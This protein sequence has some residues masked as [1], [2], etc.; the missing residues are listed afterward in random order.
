MADGA[1]LGA[2]A[3][4]PD[5]NIYLKSVYTC[6]NKHIFKDEFRDDLPKT[7]STT[8]TTTTTTPTTTTTFTTTTPTTTTLATITTET[9]IYPGVLPPDKVN[10]PPKSKD[11]EEEGPIG[12]ASLPGPSLVHRTDGLQDVPAY[13]DNN[14]INNGAAKV[15]VVTDAAEEERNNFV[16]AFFSDFFASYQHIQNHKAKFILFLT[17]SIALGLALFLAMVVWGMYR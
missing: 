5:H 17:L 7:T 4:T 1:A 14:N 2:P 6:V 11:G 10:Q 12:R 9:D 13:H 3:C 15:E 16:V 8:T